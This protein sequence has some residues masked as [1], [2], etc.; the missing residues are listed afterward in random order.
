MERLSRGAVSVGA[1]SSQHSSALA[2]FPMRVEEQ[3]AWL[4]TL[5][6]PGC[7][8]SQEWHAARGRWRMVEIAGAS[9]EN[10]NP[11][12]W[13][14]MAAFEIAPSPSILSPGRGGRE[15]WAGGGLRA[16]PR[17]FVLQPCPRGRPP[18]QDAAPEPPPRVPPLRPEL[19]ALRGRV[20]SW[21]VFFSA[22]F[23]CC[24]AFS[25]GVFFGFRVF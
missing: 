14:V 18:R 11:S 25:C 19:T 2:T 10:I 3:R 21:A 23:C 15:G 24:C 22:C 9:A 7:L 16:Q 20:Q 13:K 12:I 8:G 17:A 4:L 1:S 5:G 6:W